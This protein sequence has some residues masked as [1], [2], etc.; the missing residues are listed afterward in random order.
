VT[1]IITQTTYAGP[2][3]LMVQ[4]TGYVFNERT[5]NLF[6]GKTTDLVVELQPEAAAARE[7]PPLA[8]LVIAGAGAAGVVVGGVLLYVG[9]QDGPDDKRLY[10]C[11]TALGVAVGI[12]GIAAVGIP[13]DGAPPLCGL[14]LRAGRLPAIGAYDEAVVLEQF[15][16]AHHLSPGDRLPVVINGRLRRQQLVGIA[17]SSEYVLAISGRERVADNRRFAV[18]WMRRGAVALAFRLVVR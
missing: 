15:A 1:G 2:H 16:E 4:R 14:Y 17:L 8:P 10:T 11:A 12:A 5:I 6:A 3:K 7:G 9:Q 18:L 13:D